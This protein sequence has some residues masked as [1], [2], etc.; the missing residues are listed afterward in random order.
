[1]GQLQTF[2]AFFGG[3]Y[4][5]MPS[6]LDAKITLEI[7]LERPEQYPFWIAEVDGT[8]VGFIAGIVHAH[9]YQPTLPCLTELLWWVV[10]TYR[11]TSAG[12]R[13]LAAFV[14]YG[15]ANAKWITMVIGQNTPIK[16]KA[17][18]R[19]GFVL[20]ETNFLLEV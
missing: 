9:F 5:L 13:L 15:R 11:H 6:P 12:W 8:P 1:M 18:E 3:K 10:P 4:S 19:F 17:L 14:A 16:P 7:W 2:D 20:R